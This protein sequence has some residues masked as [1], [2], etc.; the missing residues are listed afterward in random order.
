MKRDIVIIGGGLAG[1]T[2]AQT[3][4]AEGF[5]GTITLLCQENHHPYL[6]PPLSKDFLAGREDESSL[7]PFTLDD[8]TKQDI[9]LLLGATAVAIDRDES[10]VTLAQGTVIKYGQL[11][12]ATGAS[13][14]TL[15]VPGSDLPGVHYLR[16]LEDSRHLREALLRLQP[17]QQQCNVIL[18]GSG[19]IGM[20]VAATARTM[21]A[22]VTVVGRSRVP[23]EAAIGPELGTVFMERHKEAG[24]VF[25]TETTVT[26]IVE[27]NGRAAGV[28]TDRGEHLLADLVVVAIGVT[29]NTVLAEAAG[30]TIDNG[31]LTDPSLRTNDPRIL[32]AG[33]V[34]NAFHPFT[35]GNIRSEHWANAINS[36]KVAART[37]MGKPSRLEEVPYFYTDQF[38]LGMEYSGYSALAANAK[39]V[40]RGDPASGKFIAFWLIPVSSTKGRLVAGMN[41]NIWD[42]QDDIKFL[43]AS[44]QEVQTVQLEDPGVA[45]GEL[46]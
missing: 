9:E 10:T 32:A 26:Q 2:A 16:T 24:V 5:T 3:L 37:M 6:R 19:W 30:L 46:S 8:Y 42:V 28:I 40:L 34:A 25:T 15:D 17:G 38:D 43:I 11:L 23:L 33:D 31:V 36:G 21:G 22:N 20:E 45:L 7:L 13:P 18:V 35:G 1:A 29:P 41:V 14:R 12:L 4:R 27:G 39:I 44:G